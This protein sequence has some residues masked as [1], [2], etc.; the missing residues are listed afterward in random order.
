MVDLAQ[1]I[2]FTWRDRTL[3]NLSE[4]VFDGEQRRPRHVKVKISFANPP[5]Q[6]G[7]RQ[8]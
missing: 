5:S 4:I 3:S 8:S 2:Q 1:V 6:D 7:F